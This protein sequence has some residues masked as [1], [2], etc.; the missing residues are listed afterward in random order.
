MNATAVHGAASSMP[1]GEYA[2]CYDLLYRD[3]DYAGEAAFVSGLIRRN[4][5]D[6]MRMPRLLDLACGTGRHVIELARLGYDVEGSDA[7]AAMIAQA[8]KA[9]SAAGLTT[10]FYN[11]TFQTC[12]RIG[13]QYD[14]ALAL[15]ASLNYLA[16]HD[17]WVLA[18]RNIRRLLAADGIFIFDMWNGDAVEKD[19]SPRREKRVRGGDLEILRVSETVLNPVEQTATVEFHFTLLRNG[20]MACEFSERHPLR[21]FFLQE[22]NDLLRTNGMEV[23]MRCPF[24]DSDRTVGAADW[25]VTYVVKKSGAPENNADNR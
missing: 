18:L 7:A 19:F 4:L 16:S 6:P 9:S 12:D 20:A 22:M 3:K 13:K 21:Y 2:A 8:C 1:F 14:V 23:I 11:E 10:R 25:N 15:F 24:M 17:D 5:G